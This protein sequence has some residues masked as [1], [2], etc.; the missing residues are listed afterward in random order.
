MFLILLTHLVQYFYLRIWFIFNK[1]L[2]T[3]VE[4]FIVKRGRT[5]DSSN[6]TIIT[7]N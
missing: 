4:Q 2:D 7:I 6:K 1:H 3:G 5:K